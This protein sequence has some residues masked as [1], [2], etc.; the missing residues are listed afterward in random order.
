MDCLD[1]TVQGK[2]PSM[3]KQTHT[4]TYANT[5]TLVAH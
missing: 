4:H 3:Q 5:Y 2:T 1:F